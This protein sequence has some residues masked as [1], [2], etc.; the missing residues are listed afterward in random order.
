MSLIA[1]FSNLVN[2]CTLLPGG[3][4]AM[5]LLEAICLILSWASIVPIAARE[6]FSNQWLLTRT[7]ASFVGSVGTRCG[8]TSQALNAFVGI[9]G[10]SGEIFSLRY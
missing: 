2:T 3:V 5:P 10:G 4:R 8:L 9:V 1:A 6:W 7:D